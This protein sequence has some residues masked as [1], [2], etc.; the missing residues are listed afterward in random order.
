[1][2]ASPGQI[3]LNSDGSYGGGI[4][5]EITHRLATLENFGT[6]LNDFRNNT[7]E[8]RKRED[9]YTVVNKKT[10]IAF[11]AWADNNFMAG[12]HTVIP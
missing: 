8:F 4:E 9:R 6:Q 10:K 3:V 7:E 12:I 1:M 2:I 5:N 11:L